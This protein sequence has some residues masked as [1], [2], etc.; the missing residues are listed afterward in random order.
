MM[1]VDTNVISELMRDRPSPI[2][3]L[4]FNAQPASCLFLTSIAEAEIRT[5]IALLPNGKRQRG[6]AAAAE[7]FFTLFTN[8]ILAFDRA[9]AHDYATTFASC[10][11]AGRPISQADCQIAAIAR[12]HGA[13]VA[14]RNVAHFRGAGL[15]LIDPWRT[16]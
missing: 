3:L 4:W 1:V 14:T 15:K 13:A 2:V 16:S 8:R 6:L 5:G 11:A 12:S 7:R 9:A 10:R